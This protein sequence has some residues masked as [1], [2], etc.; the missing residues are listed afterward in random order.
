MI[1]KE[2]S[3]PS[4]DGKT[5]IHAIRWIP[6]KPRAVVQLSH[7]V[8]EYADRYDPFASFLCEQ[9]FLVVANDHLG[10]GQSVLKGTRPMYFGPKGSW[11]FVVDDLHSLHGQT[12]KKFPDLPYFLLGHSMGSFLARTHLIRYP[13][14]V[15]AAVLMGT[16]QMTPAMVRLGLLI[17]NIYGRQTGWDQPNHIVDRLAFGSYNAVFAPN[18]TSHDWLSVDTANVDAFLAD[19]LCVLKPSIGMFRE[20]LYGIKFIT[21]QKN[22][23][24]MDRGTPVLFVSGEMDPVGDCGKGV[25]RAADSFRKA[26][27]TTVDVKLYPELRHEILNE[28]CK[29]DVYRDVLAWLEARMAPQSAPA[30]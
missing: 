16:G 20:M 11:S 9:G 3:Y 5:S 29:E 15:D 1:K 6:E 14:A 2:F 7:G 22:V 8:A 24:K 27:L 10:H 19:P 25:L 13:G 21:N 26:G 12:R 23:E 28:A 18:R 30:I 4:A 17:A